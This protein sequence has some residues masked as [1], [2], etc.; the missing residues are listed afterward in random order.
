LREDGATR[1]GTETMHVLRAEKGFVIIGQD[2]DGTVIPDDLGLNRTIASGKP[3]FVGRRSLT[4]PD[5]LRD[6]R[7][8]LVGLLTADPTVVLEEG[9]Q[10]TATGAVSLGHVT[11][12]YHSATLSRSIALA[13]FAG[14]RSRIGTTLLVPLTDRTIEVTVTDPIFYDPAGGRM[15]VSI[16]RSSPQSARSLVAMPFTPPPA[17][18]CMEVAIALAP[19]TRNF[20]IRTQQPI[21]PT[22]RA[23]TR[24]GNTALWLGPDEYFVIGDAPPPIAADS[25]VDVSH[26][27]VAFRVSGSRAAWCLNAFCGLDLDT[28]PQ[29]FCTRTLLGKAEIILWYLGAAEFH[30]ETARSY[31]PYV[32]ALFEEARREFLP[33]TA[34]C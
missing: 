23:V 20:G 5:M 21:A 30:I 7:K 18:S 15:T 19:A 9:A 27:T 12:A 14:G 2:T 32:W 24:D 17:L 3:D 26:R 16:A 22:L 33:A 11:S 34:A 25:I 1:Y 6:D 28:V 10:L 29:N 4:R 31:A 13:L 8:Q